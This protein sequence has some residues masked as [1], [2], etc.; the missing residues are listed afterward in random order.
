MSSLTK[1]LKRIS[2][3]LGMLESIGKKYRGSRDRE[4]QESSLF[5]EP[6]DSQEGQRKAYA[7]PKDPNGQ[8]SDGQVSTPFPLEFPASDP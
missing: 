2:Q 6:M 3:K 1:G 8:A 7:E 4:I 5:P